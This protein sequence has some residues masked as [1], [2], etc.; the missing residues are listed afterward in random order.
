MEQVPQ[1]SAGKAAKRSRKKPNLTE[2]SVEQVLQFLANAE[3]INAWEVSDKKTGKAAEKYRMRRAL[4]EIDQKIM[5]A[6]K[7]IIEAKARCN[8]VCNCC[9]NPAEQLTAA[10]IGTK[11]AD[12]VD[13]IMNEHPDATF[14]EYYIYLV[15]ANKNVELVI[16][17]R[18][19]NN[20]IEEATRVSS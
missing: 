16:V 13:K 7:K 3:R 4:I 1:L 15:E 12:I 11:R 6:N 8:G 2:V 19:C 10:H 17:C 14:D 20:R 9:G 5:L 18:P